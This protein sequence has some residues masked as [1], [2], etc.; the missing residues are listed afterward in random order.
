MPA[1]FGDGLCFA[2]YTE[3]WFFEIVGEL[4]WFIKFI[5]FHICI[6]IVLPDVVRHYI[7]RQALPDESFITDGTNKHHVRRCPTDAHMELRDLA[8][9]YIQLASM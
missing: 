9:V 8:S 3:K 1:W 7:I 6:H 5:C 4:W 2:R